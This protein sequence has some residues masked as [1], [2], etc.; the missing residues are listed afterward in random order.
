MVNKMARKKKQKVLALDTST[1]K[2][3]W[4]LFINGKYAE[5]GVIDFHR[6]KKA[7]ERIRKM[8]LAV[9]TLIFDK[10]PDNIV[11]E[12]LSSTRNADTTRKLSRIIGA[13]YY[14]CISADINYKEMSCDTWRGLVGIKNSKGKKV[15]ADSINRVLQKYRLDVDDNEADAINICDAFCLQKRER[16]EKL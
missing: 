9:A 12:Q 4:A 10:S 1:S 6:E 13:V 11:I 16:K 7:E 2:T 14:Y 8:C 5:S 15:K 3:G